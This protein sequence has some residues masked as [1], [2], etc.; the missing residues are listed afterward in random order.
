MMQ[1]GRW[2]LAACNRISYIGCLLASCTYTLACICIP[3]SVLHLGLSPASLACV[4][5]CNT[6]VCT[7][8]SLGQ[9]QVVAWMSGHAGVQAAVLL[10][11]SLGWAVGAQ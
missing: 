1:Q 10:Q 7:H 8:L 2:K 6:C 3:G 5:I 4:D 9:Q 11:G